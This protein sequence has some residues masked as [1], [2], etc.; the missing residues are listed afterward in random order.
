MLTLTE[1]A[2]AVITGIVENASVADSGGLRISQ[3]LGNAGLDVA[4][5]AAPQ[6][7]D[8]VV[9]SAGAKVFLDPTAA[10]AL[11]D[12]VLDASAADDGR[13]DF[14]VGQQD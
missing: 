12:K 6:D 7:E 9:Q 14:R 1:N 5:A 8:Q 2:Q 11:D 10:A 3:E 13:V 4:V